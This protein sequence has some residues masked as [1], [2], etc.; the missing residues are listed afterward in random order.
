MKIRLIPLCVAAA[1][2]MVSGMGMAQ[3]STASPGSM[4][5]AVGLAVGQNPE[6]LSKWHAFGS[7]T[8]QQDVAFGR[9]LPS[10]DLDAQSGREHKRTPIINPERKY[11]LYGATLTLRQLLFDGLATPSEVKRLGHAARVRYFELLDA[12]ENAAYEASKAYLDVLRYRQQVRYA[13]ENYALHRVLLQQMG[14]R[15]QAGVGR[16][17]DLE[18]AAGRMALAETNLLTEVAN[19]HDVSARYQRVVG[20]SPA[21]ELGSPASLTKEVMPTA[22]ENLVRAL[23]RS[24]QLKASME[25]IMAAE[26]DKDVQR[27]AFMPKVY[28]EAQKDAFHNVDGYNGKSDTTSVGVVMHWNLLNGGSDNARMK[29]YAEQVNLAKDLRDKACRDIRQTL[30]IAFNE[31][32]SLSQKLAFLDQHQIS[33]EKAR[34]AFRQ[35]FDI[36]QR[37]LLDLLDTENEYYDARRAYNNGAYDLMV[38]EARLQAVSGNLLSVLGLAPVEAN[39]PKEV[40]AM[41][42]DVTARCPAEAPEVAT[43]DKEKLFAEAMENAKAALETAQRATPPAANGK[44]GKR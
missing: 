30:L 19:L 6:V 43:P 28:F 16:K 14:E 38:A 34:V 31:Y 44:A 8:H 4:K 5:E 12:S 40:E 3:S 23:D 39:A 24:P 33:I 36:G 17:V 29:Q 21:R 25:N 22:K 15:V 20:V 11:D 41:G 37:T 13:E 10:L 18:L 7:S 1:M 27:A 2:A 9:Y 42:D 32:R 26:R 35:Q